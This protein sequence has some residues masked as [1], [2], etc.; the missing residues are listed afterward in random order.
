MLGV[1]ACLFVVGIDAVVTRLLP[2]LAFLTLA[3]WTAHFLPSWVASAIQR[4]SGPQPVELASGVESILL[5]VSLL[6]TVALLAI[7]AWTSVTRSDVS[8]VRRR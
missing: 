8:R 4:G 3:A 7:L 5:A 1:L 6:S 2:V